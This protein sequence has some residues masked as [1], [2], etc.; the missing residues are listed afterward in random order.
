MLG[1]LTVVTAGKIT[2]DGETVITGNQSF[3][4]GSPGLPSPTHLDLP[5][6]TVMSGDLTAGTVGTITFSFGFS[7]QS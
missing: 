2:F 3:T 7:Q 6:P 1:D 5:S 4:V